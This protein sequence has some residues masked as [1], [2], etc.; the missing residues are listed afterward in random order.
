MKLKTKHN[1][2]AIA[3]AVGV[4]QATVSNWLSLITKPTGLGRANLVKHFPDLA[5]RI[6]E[7]WKT[8]SNSTM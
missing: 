4:T 6:E 7:A 8:K 5:E 3:A 2:Q 1:Q